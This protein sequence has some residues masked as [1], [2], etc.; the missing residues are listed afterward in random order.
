MNIKHF[1]DTSALLHQAGLIT[2]EVNIAIST[3][4]V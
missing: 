3:I 1:A 4:T 2:P